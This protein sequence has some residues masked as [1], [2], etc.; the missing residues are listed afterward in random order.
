VLKRV[1]IVAAAFV[2]TGKIVTPNGLS[3]ELIDVP[4]MNNQ[5]W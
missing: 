4:L 3:L 5:L 1:A 2:I